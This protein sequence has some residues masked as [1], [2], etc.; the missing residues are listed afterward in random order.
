MNVCPKTWMAE[1]ILVTLF[2]C[3]PFGIIGIINASKVSSLYATGCIEAAQEASKE[4]K[5]W[6]L[7][8]FICSL[9]GTFLYIIVYACGFAAFMSAANI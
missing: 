7:I 9:V 5:K 6:T 2:C 8:G 3:L 1:S 4:A